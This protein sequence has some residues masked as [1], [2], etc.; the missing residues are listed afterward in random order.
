MSDDDIERAIHEAQQFAR[1][2]A[3]NKRKIG[4]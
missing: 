4:F 1:E 3:H 2:D